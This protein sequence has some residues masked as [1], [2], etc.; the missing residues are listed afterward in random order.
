MSEFRNRAENLIRPKKGLWHYDGHKTNWK[1]NVRNAPLDSYY[2][3][4]KYSGLDNGKL[5]HYIQIG[6]LYSDIEDEDN[7]DIPVD[8]R[9]SVIKWLVVF[10][11]LW[12]IFYFVEI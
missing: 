4:K 5:M 6:S 12:I 3:S 10:I 7:K 8:R 9:F 1:L 11:L 2:S